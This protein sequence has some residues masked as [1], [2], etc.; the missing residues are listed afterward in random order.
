MWQTPATEVIETALARL[1]LDTKARLLAGHD[2]WSLPAV[3]EIGLRAVV[4]SDGPVGVRG[5][6]WSP[7][8][9]S[10]A[11]PSPTA[12][13]AT[14][15]ARLVHRVGQLLAR[16]ARRKNADVLLAPTI[17]LHRSP[18]GG[19]H[20]ECFSEDPLLTGVIAAAFVDGVQSGKVAAVVKHFVAND[21]ETERFSM[22]VRI[23]DRALREV[24]LA[25]FEHVVTRARPWGVMSAYN[26]VNG[27]SMT[28][29]RHLQQ[30]VLRG[31]WGFDGV[32]VSD[33]GAARDTVRAIT[34][35]LDVAMPGP[36]TVYGEHLADAVRD[37]RVDERLV[38]D[39]VRH[40]LLLA[41][42]VGALEGPHNQRPTP[43]RRPWLGT[44][45][46][47]EGLDGAELARRTAAR[48]FVLLKNPRSVL[49]LSPR[50]LTCVAV[51]GDAAE[52]AR[53]MGGGSATVFPPHTVTPLD[54]LR[55][56]LPGDVEVV[57]A[58]GADPRTSLAPARAGF[59]LRSRFRAADGTVLADLPQPDG[60]VQM[61][62]SLPAGVSP[63]RL[64][65]V[66]ISGRFT[67]DRD[68][69]H[70][71]GVSGYGDVVLTVDGHTLFDA[72]RVPQTDDPFLAVMAPTEVRRETK[73]TAGRP[74]EVTLSCVPYGADLGDG[75]P[76][77]SVCLGHRPPTASEDELIEEAVV[78]AAGADVAVVVVSTTDEV[79]S[80]GFDRTD[81]RLPGRQDDLVARV[82]QANP[83]T[84]VVVNAG[85][86]VEMPWREQVA[87]I[88]VTWFP[89]QEAGHALADVLLGVREPGG[90]L[91]TTWP[92]A[93]ADCPVL[94]THPHD[95]VLSYDEGVHVGY[96]AWQRHSTPPAYWFGHGLG[97]T[98]WAY[99]RADF[100]P[101]DEQE[102][103]GLLGVVRA[104]LCNTGVR[105]GREIVQ[106][107]IE[108]Q[109]DEQLPAPGRTTH[110][111]PLRWLAGFT[112]LDCARGESAVAEI[113]VPRRAVQV[114]DADSASW[115]T[116]G[117]P[118]RIRIGRSYADLRLDVDLK[119]DD[120][121]A[122][123]EPP[124]H[125]SRRA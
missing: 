125:P 81:L 85:S 117:G 53:I 8:D 19:R 68:G 83:D 78:A 41:A 17:N 6:R 111:R 27:T 116:V 30:E 82:A 62:G 23:S 36:N 18:L 118:Y 98:E 112:V 96:R 71:F 28:E 80:E 70:T 102:G 43:L 67:P 106:A 50:R 84:V 72:H 115:H 26:G 9:P 105:Q 37:G 29:N 7:D 57:Y 40:V 79:E 32:T 31:E 51:I 99:E 2:M 13:A 58:Q 66:T 46:P 11:L 52:E 12:L 89:G 90:R 120:T 60:R 20:F 77:L 113:S 35:G 122:P 14:W 69:V 48:S 88:L 42:R 95:G 49:P 76:S 54:G 97:Y 5:T 114:W 44:D 87:A 93:T 47:E 108:P 38:D 16:E 103:P 39:A 61:M 123:H 10:V 45:G 22:D 34:G 55:N 110:D 92:S 100:H 25:P 3:P 63:D 24:Y 21:S 65:S 94:E 121:D 59:E 104:T 1:D 91:P 124:G 119:V 73:L 64:H 101:G 4:M 75:I 74:V 56:A 33:W 109:R 86:P 107:Y 15:D